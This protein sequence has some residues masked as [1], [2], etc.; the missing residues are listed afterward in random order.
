MTDK[1]TFHSSVLKIISRYFIYPILAAITVIFIWLSLGEPE[2]NLLLKFSLFNGAMLLLLIIIE[3]IF[4]MR[5]EWK[6]TTSSFFK[7]DLMFIILSSISINLADKIID[8]VA[9]N[10][11][12]YTWF[13]NTPY[14]LG[15]LLA[16][17][18]TDF[19]TYW[20]HRLCHASNGFMWNI[21]FPHHLPKELYILMASVGHPI[22]FIISRS[23]FAF[24]LFF[25]GFSPEIVFTTLV[26]T[27]FQGLVSHFNIDSRVGWLNYVLVGTELHRYHHSATNSKAKNFGVVVS[28]WDQLFGTFHYD[29][30][31]IPDKLGL[32]ID[33]NANYPSDS[34]VIRILLFPLLNLFKNK[35]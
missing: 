27:T 34:N 25:L 35:S 7:R 18:I 14:L 29:P 31:N 9:L 12:P 30:K 1:L 11:E 2:S 21:H 19:I 5:K 33:D 23:T 16:V 15:V 32:S 8:L 17:L 24:S 28:I 10:I 3:A 26:I 4:P 13:N 22:N 6:M 20:I